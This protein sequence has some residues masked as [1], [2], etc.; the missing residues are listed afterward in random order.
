MALA[1]HSEFKVS[2]QTRR[3]DLFRLLWRYTVCST[4]NCSPMLAINVYHRPQMD[5]SLVD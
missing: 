4:S 2:G 1:F 5:H 3:I